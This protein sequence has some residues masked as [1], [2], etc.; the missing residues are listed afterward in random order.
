MIELAGAILLVIGAL[1]A[2]AV[3][4]TL[5]WLVIA[6]WIYWGRLL[7]QRREARWTQDE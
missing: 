7:R 1:F 5:L 6:E 2:G 4:L 3:A